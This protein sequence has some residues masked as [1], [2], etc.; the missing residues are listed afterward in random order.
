MPR[1]AHSRQRERV[2]EPGS[3]R[4]G[5]H[6]RRRSRRASHQRQSQPL[7]DPRCGGSGRREVRDRSRRRRGRLG[8][9]R[10]HRDTAVPGGLSRC[11]RGGGERRPRRA[12]LLV[13]P[14]AVGEPDRPGLPD[15]RGRDDAAGDDLR[16]IVH[17]RGCRGRRGPTALTE[18]GPHRESDRRGAARDRQ[19]GGGRRLRASRSRRR[20]P[21]AGAAQ[22]SVPGA[23]VTPP[24][25]TT[26]T[27]AEACAGPAVHEADALRDGHVQAGVPLDVQGR[28]A[29]DSRC[30][31]SHRSRAPAH[32][33][34]T[35]RAS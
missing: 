33:R 20:V 30:S 19:A 23:A 12:L 31:C 21:L 26:P 25:A 24:A 4:G 1:D 18:P 7:G 2:G 11:A 29:G 15:G 9:E 5:H 10:R 3:D 8:G 14:R 13:E 28:D 6:V 16:H 17:T 35:R 27:G 34:S 32:S 22:C